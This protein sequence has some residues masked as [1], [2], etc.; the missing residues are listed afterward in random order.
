MF[1]TKVKQLTRGMYFGGMDKIGMQNVLVVYINAS[2]D[3]VIRGIYTRQKAR[4]YTEKHQDTPGI[5][6]GIPLERFA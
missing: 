2:C 3:S 5:N 4:A 1:P 6:H